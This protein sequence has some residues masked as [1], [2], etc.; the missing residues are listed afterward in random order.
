MPPEEIK[1][2]LAKELEALKAKNAEYEAK[3]KELSVKTDPK[4]EPKED[5]ELIEKARLKKAEDDKKMGDNKALENALKFSLKSEEWL[6]VNASLLPKEIGDIFKQAETEKY[7][8]AIE[9][10]GALKSGIVQAF[11]K[12]QENLDLLTASQKSNLDEYLKLTKNEKQVQAQ[13]IYDSIFE[14]TFETL[15]RVKKAEALSKGL[16]TGGD[17]GYKNRLI[18]GSKKHFFGGQ[19]NA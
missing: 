15:K 5:P 18:E 16:G 2:D 13:K 19:K 12:V 1:P 11:F 17:D 4:P 6:K 3:I 10:D 9:K 8:S 7:D 14:P